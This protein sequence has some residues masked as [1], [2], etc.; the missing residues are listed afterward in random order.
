MPFLEIFV[1]F[2]IFL[3][4][5]RIAG[6]AHEILINKAYQNNILINLKKEYILE[7]KS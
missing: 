4:L 6:K 7:N 1:I 3:F 5:L 2:K